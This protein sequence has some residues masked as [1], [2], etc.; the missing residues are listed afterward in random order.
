MNLDMRRKESVSST[1]A[2][3]WPWSALHVERNS[4][5]EK[6][7]ALGARGEPLVQLSGSIAEPPRQHVVGNDAEAD[8]VGDCH[9][10]ASRLQQRGFQALH[11][12]IEILL[13]E[14]KV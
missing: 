2:S 5:N 11:F 3:S 13:G 4:R 10:A 6:D 9:D 1:S 7:N 8:L 14:Q 12:Q